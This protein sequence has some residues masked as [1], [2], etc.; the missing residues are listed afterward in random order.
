M[1]AA[2]IDRLRHHCHIVNI[3]GS[4]YRM[5]KHTDLSKILRSPS[6]EPSPSA[7]ERNQEQHAHSGTSRLV[8]LRG[9][10]ARASMISKFV[11]RVI[12]KTYAVALEKRVDICL[13]RGMVSFT[14]DDFPSDALYTGGSILED[15]GW[16]GTYY[17]AT[18]LLGTEAPCGRIAQTNDLQDCIKRGHEIANHTLSHLNCVEA[19]RRVLVHEIEENQRALPSNATRNLAYPFGLVDTRVSRILS[20]RVTT[21]RGIQGGIN[22]LRT[23]AMNLRANS[24]YSCNGLDRVLS[25]I[26]ENRMIRGWLVLYTHDVNDTPS[27]FGC[28]PGDLRAVTRAVK[29]AD[30]DVVTIED[31]RKRL[32][33]GSA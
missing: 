19:N 33:M 31:G 17:T 24:I 8:A 5:R 12:N 25:Y 21:G 28:T 32:L 1:A 14:F 15:A 2:L 11:T 10:Q 20:D 16:R 27:Q 9:H 7:G 18:G 26:E 30:F 3:R 6:A 22:A 4:S 13:E 29:V 23:V